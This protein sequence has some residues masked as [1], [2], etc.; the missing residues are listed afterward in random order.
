MT[1]LLQPQVWA[2]WHDFFLL[3]PNMWTDGQTDEQTDRVDITTYEY[4]LDNDP[5]ISIAV[6]LCSLPIKRLIKN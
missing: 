6:L 4:V 1:L 2:A 3:Q 5:H